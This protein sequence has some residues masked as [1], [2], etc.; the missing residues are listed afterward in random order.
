MSELIQLRVDR[1][2]SLMP[3]LLP[4]T[5]RGAVRAFGRFVRL[6]EAIA[7]SPLLARNKRLA[8]LAAL[9]AALER[10]PAGREAGSGSTANAVLSAADEAVM[11]ALCDSLARH[12][13]GTAHARKILQT[14]QQSL[15]E[16]PPAGGDTHRNG[17]SVLHATWSDVV[18]YGAGVAAPIGRQMLDLC[19]EEAERCGPPADA[20]CIAMRIL[21]ELR[22]C[23]SPTDPG[24]LRCIPADFMR[25]ASITLRHLSAPAARG[26]TRAVLDRVLD[27]VDALL[28]EAAALPGRTRNRRLRT[29]I[30]VVLCR[31]R[32]LS[33]RCRHD[34]P[35]Q[36][37]VELG[38]WQ[39]QTCVLL[40]LMHGLVRP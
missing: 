20:L 1:D 35:L 37:R 11:A 30:R 7:A 34:D 32:K 26:Q 21:K 12:R 3:W 24:S 29:Y 10:C 5:I 19:G 27:G 23:D 40:N 9:E 14:L 16:V 4:A 38:E 28:I 15:V 2:F 36:D 39:R 31:A 33:S 17:P 18:A 8:R 13:V 6:A 22:D 25:D